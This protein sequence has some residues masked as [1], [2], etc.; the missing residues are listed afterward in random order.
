MRKV[1]IATSAIL[2]LSLFSG[3]STKQVAKHEI[4]HIKKEKPYQFT[5]TPIIGTQNPDERVIVNMGTVMRVWINS[6]KDRNGDLVASH[7]TY[8]WMKKPDFIVGNELPTRNRGLLTPDGRMPT[9]LS[10]SEVD[11]SNFSSNENIKQYVNG[12]YQKS[13]GDNDLTKDISKHDLKIKNFLKSSKGETEW[14]L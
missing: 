6:Y 4:I 11:R 7:D 1:L 2:A 12:V 13:S 3:C 5:Y 8:T 14:L 10:S 9:M